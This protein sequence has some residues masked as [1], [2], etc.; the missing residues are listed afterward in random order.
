M[1]A[2]VRVI[3]G[4]PADKDGRTDFGVRGKLVGDWF[5]SSL[6]NDSA[7]VI[8]TSTGWSKSISFA[9][10]WF[11]H[12]PRIS[13]GGTISAPGAF[14]IAT[15]DPDPATVSVSSGLVAYQCASVLGLSQSGWVLVQMITDE[16]MRVEYFASPAARPT[17]FTSA[18]QEYVR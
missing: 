11:S 17:A 3:D 14:S 8:G 4:V 13:I 5:H 16:R 6:A 12:A 7:Y 15:S 9:Y 10:D 2:H 1:Y 18:A